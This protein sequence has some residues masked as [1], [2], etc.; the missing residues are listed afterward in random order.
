MMLKIHEVIITQPCGLG[1]YLFS[2]KG[3]KEA[4]ANVDVFYR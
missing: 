1:P 4:G 2:L 3:M